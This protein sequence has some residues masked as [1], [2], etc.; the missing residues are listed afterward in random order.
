MASGTLWPA[1]YEHCPEQ[2]N[3]WVMYMRTISWQFLAKWM[4]LFWKVVECVLYVTTCRLSFVFL[5][6]T[7]FYIL[8]HWSKRIIL[9]KISLNLIS[10]LHFKLQSNVY[11]ICNI[12]IYLCHQNFS[13]ASAVLSFEIDTTMK[14]LAS[15]MCSWNSDLQCSCYAD[16]C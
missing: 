9:F 3:R 15:Q 11:T 10:A 7:M 6:E 2:L 12:K 1:V 5:N 13:Q 14:D 16:I 8:D 4:Q